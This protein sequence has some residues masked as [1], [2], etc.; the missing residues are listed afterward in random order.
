MH[1]AHSNTP[2]RARRL[3]HATPSADLSQPVIPSLV[4][5]AANER[6]DIRFILYAVV[7]LLLHD[8]VAP[9]NIAGQ[10]AGETTGNRGLARKQ[11]L[12]IWKEPLAIAKQPTTIQLA[13]C[14]GFFITANTDCQGKELLAIR[15]TRANLQRHARRNNTQLPTLVNINARCRC[16]RCSL[17]H[18]TPRRM[19]MKCDAVRRL[20]LED[21]FAHSAV[22]TVY[23]NDVRARPCE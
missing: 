22:Q 7:R 2:Q 4:P 11:L 9:R 5:I 6:L 21:S 17:M 12:A 18:R 15:K 10:N 16:M 23:A 8:G 20:I 1:A 14:H 3:A 19:I 13:D